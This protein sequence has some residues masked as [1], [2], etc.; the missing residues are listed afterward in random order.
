L[1]KYILTTTSKNSHNPNHLHENFAYLQVTPQSATSIGFSYATGTMEP[2]V[3]SRR[4]WEAF[5]SLLAI[6][7]MELGGAYL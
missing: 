7:S 5:F 3:V 1:G 2:A 6:K 4:H